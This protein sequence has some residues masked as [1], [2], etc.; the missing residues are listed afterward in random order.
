MRP[1]SSLVP[2]LASVALLVTAC[3]GDDTSAPA[4]PT[5]VAPSSV[6]SPDPSSESVPADDATPESTIDGTDPTDSPDSTASPDTT[7]AADDSSTG[8][9]SAA[10]GVLAPGPQPIDLR[11]DEVVRYETDGGTFELT[12]QDGWVA[13]VTP[14]S[15]WFTTMPDIGTAWVSIVHLKDGHPELGP[16]GAD[17]A[18]V[19]IA[20]DPLASEDSLTG[21]EGLPNLENLR[22][23]PDDWFAYLSSLPGL[24]IDPPAPATFGAVTGDAAAY[25]VGDVA[26][27]TDALCGEGLLSWVEGNGSWCFA[28]GE[29]GTVMIT[30]IDGARF[31]LNI[32]TTERAT[33]DDRAALDAIVA[34]LRA[35]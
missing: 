23:L 31:E 13:W 7:I 12:G 6:P 14:V 21:T 35:V 29:S 15:V 8:A 17:L 33:D 27:V 2:L 28:E 11:T 22:P 24:S 4:A 3:G 26:T 9:G 19:A 25:T 18:G 16:A 30:E 34:S 10:D 20:A 1:C 32:G 5:S